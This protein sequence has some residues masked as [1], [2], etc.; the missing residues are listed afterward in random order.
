MNQ[1]I[2][3]V[4]RSSVSPR[5]RA[6]LV[7]LS[8]SLFCGCAATEPDPIESASPRAASIAAMNLSAAA[9]SGQ[10]TGVRSTSARLTASGSLCTSGATLKPHP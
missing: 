5:T 8:L 1:S 9:A 10:R 4:V 6:I 2:L 7:G 3:P